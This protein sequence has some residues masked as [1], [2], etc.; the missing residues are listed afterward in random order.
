VL[1]RLYTTASLA[2]EIAV[3]FADAVADKARELVS[4]PA[5]KEARA[6]LRTERTRVKNSTS[7]FD[8][9]VAERMALDAER[10]QKQQ[11]AS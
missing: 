6:T 5:D 1:E 7:W 3:L 8:V 2:H 11:K 10:E 4:L 9:L